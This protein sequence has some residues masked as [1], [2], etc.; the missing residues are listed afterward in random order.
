MLQK[1]TR[2]EADQY[3]LNFWKPETTLEKGIESVISSLVDS[4]GNLS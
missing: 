4:S 1:D 3:V 2:N